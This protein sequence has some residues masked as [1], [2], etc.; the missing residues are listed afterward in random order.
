MS[1]NR[2]L[3]RRD[4]TLTKLD[5]ALD[6]LRVLLAEDNKVNQQ[7]AEGILKRRGVQV[8]LVGNGRE[9]LEALEA[10]PESYDLMLMDLEMP[11]LDGY[12]TTDAIRKGKV[13]PDIPIV[14][15]TAQAIRGD[16][17]HCLQAG[18]DAYVSKPISPDE[19]YRVLAHIVCQPTTDS[20]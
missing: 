7:V 4:Q 5:F 18:M 11:E 14:A 9:A 2:F 6:G 1:E 17:E 10:N 12:E 13:K 8:T 16:R 15:L 19:L 3:G 20:D